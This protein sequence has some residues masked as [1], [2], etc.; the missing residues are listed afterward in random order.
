[1]CHVA[2]ALSLLLLSPFQRSSSAATILAQVGS[3]KITVSAFK[4]FSESLPEGYTGDKTGFAADSLLL[5]SLVDKTALLLEAESLGIHQEPWLDP[6]LTRFREER[7]LS[8]YVTR[9]INQKVVY[10]E[11]ELMEHFRRTGRDRALRYAGIGVETR[12]EALEILEE[13]EAGADFGELAMERSFDEETRDQG[14]DFGKYF[15]KDGAPPAFRNH[16]FS[17]QVGEVSEPLP[18]PGGTLNWAIFKIL[19]EVPM[20]LADV[21]LLVSEEVFGRK[22]D[23]RAV[24]LQDSLRAE[25]AP[26]VN[27]DFVAELV[28]MAAA[29]DTAGAAALDSGAVICTYRG[30]QIRLRDLRDLSPVEH[31]WFFSDADS[32]A[33]FLQSTIIPQLISLEEAF[34]AGLDKDPSILSA[35]KKKRDDEV[36][37]ALR[38]REL[39]LD[40]TVS[41]AE[42][43]T[44]Y[45]EH[46]EL[47]QTFDEMEAIEI[48]V[49][50]KNL[51][52][53]LR[54]QLDQGADPEQLASNYTIREGRSHHGGRVQLGTVTRY[55]EVY[56]AA[57]DLQVG[58]IG[59]PVRTQD[60]YSVFQI[61]S[62]NPPQLKPYHEFSQRR[63][64]AYVRSQKASRAYVDYVRGLRQKY[65][66]KIFWEEFESVAD[67]S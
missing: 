23:E 15:A 12:E 24:F 49:T 56:E 66:A 5:E 64:R 6:V 19:D 60:G 34:A 13:L 52:Q 31:P 27:L 3:E 51:A 29:R 58:D 43:R 65:S 44:F 53:Q 61:V 57:K 39:D 22:R 40:V 9:E 33:E 46:P 2:L 1:M 21:E 67:Q 50:F 16:L 8:L 42:A 28:A 32:L 20:Q 4:D 63:A 54:E 36:V 30:G 26:Q 59:G 48:L 35:I 38:K 25:Y 45:D 37:S 55:R 47:F 41:D 10:T 11:Q 17:M 62:R 18:V 7:I 14:G